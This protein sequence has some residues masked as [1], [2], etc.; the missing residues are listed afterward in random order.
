MGW[1]WGEGDGGGMEMEV[2]VGWRWRWKW[3]Y[4]WDGGRLGLGLE[5]DGLYLP[6]DLGA[7]LMYIKTRH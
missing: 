2:W 3:G 1:R 6:E 5:G 4:R 7:L